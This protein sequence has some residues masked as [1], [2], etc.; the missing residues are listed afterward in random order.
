MR[1]N[2]LQEAGSRVIV[3]GRVWERS[4]LPEGRKIVRVRQKTGF[5]RV[6]KRRCGKPILVEGKGGN[7]GPFCMPDLTLATDLGCGGAVVVA[8]ES[9]PR[10]MDDPCK[11]KEGNHDS[12]LRKLLLPRGGGPNEKENIR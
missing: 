1:K 12:R 10:M 8:F 3:K 2:V 11:K 5:T 9:Y 6:G 4:G 7:Q